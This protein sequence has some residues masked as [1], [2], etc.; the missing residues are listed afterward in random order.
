MSK[1]LVRIE[2]VRHST[3]YHLKELRT[4]QMLHK[5]I[6]RKRRRKEIGGKLN[7]TERMQETIDENSK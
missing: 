3:F 1:K 2:K 4:R 5:P 7:T 6:F